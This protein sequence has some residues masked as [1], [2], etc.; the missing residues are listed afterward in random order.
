M[1]KY[2]IFMV[3]Q[4]LFCVNNIYF[5]VY[6]SGEIDDTSNLNLEENG[7]LGRAINSS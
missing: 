5:V 4:L 1:K 7:K 6:A 3:V 2:F